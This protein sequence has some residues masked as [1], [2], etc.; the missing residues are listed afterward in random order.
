[1]APEIDLV[2]GKPVKNK[3]RE[4]LSALT[5]EEKAAQKAAR[6]AEK[7]AKR[8]AKKAGKGANTD[9]SA[10]DSGASE[11]TPEDVADAIAR[12]TASG[13]GGGDAAEPALLSGQEMLARQRAVT[14]VLASTPTSANTK[15]EKFSVTVAGQSLLDDATLELNVGTRSSART[16]AVRPTS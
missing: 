7:E 5:P 4:L 6:A 16:V 11:E 8:A 9:A 3:A 1:M 12:L 15:I 14:G 13:G 2:T 10:K